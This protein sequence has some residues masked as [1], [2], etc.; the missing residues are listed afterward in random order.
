MRAAGSA[1]PAPLTFLMLAGLAIVATA[2]PLA[3]P[4]PEL[5][6]LPALGLPVALLMWRRPELALF[7]IVALIPFGAIRK[8]G[9]IDLPWV[10]A[11]FL[12][13][14]MVLRIAVHRRLP[15]IPA[16][17][18]WFAFALYVV[19]NV[20]AAALSPD[21]SIAVKTTI[22]IAASGLFILLVQA[23]LT[24]HGL[25]HAL[26]RVV[27]WSVTAGSMLG[28]VGLLTGGA[29]FGEDMPDGANFRAVGGAIDP[30]NQAIMIVFA[31]PLVVHLILYAESRLERW[32]MVGVALVNVVGVMTTVSRSGFVMLVLVCLM[33]LIHHRRRVF[34]RRGVSALIVAGVLGIGAA[35]PFIPASFI[36]RQLSLFAWED[37]SL[38]R[39]ATYLEVAEAAVLDKPWLGNGP[40]TFHAIYGRSEQTR[41]FTTQADRMNRK[42]H[43]T[44][45]EVVVGSG[46]VGLVLFLAFI[47]FSLWTLVRTQL[48]LKRAG[49]PVGADL[50]AC[51][52][53]G[54][55]VLLLFLLMLSDM[56]HKFLLLAIGLSQACV[57]L[58]PALLNAPAAT[59]HPA[60]FRHGGAAFPPSPPSPSLAGGG[61][62]PAQGDRH[63]STRETDFRPRLD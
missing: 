1:A 41:L 25:R 26:H 43:N 33:L 23:F 9:P 11:A 5:A 24:P 30:N 28:L 8:I 54:F 48:A 18:V 36:E 12:L 60:R 2:V 49:D 14:V 21:R 20:V 63:A 10:L 55:I 45:L 40:G 59:S 52:R 37:R 31:L 32:V 34:T 42:A 61:T 47:G 50:L 17:G 46:L 29:A 62:P 35:A 39:R 6:V 53:I 13:G 56:Q 15:A 51:W 22:L 19:V 4:H 38:N 27:V 3:T 44:Y 57:V 58:A 16:T 7:A